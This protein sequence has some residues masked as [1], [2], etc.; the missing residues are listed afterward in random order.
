[1]MLLLFSLAAIASVLIGWRHGTPIEATEEAGFYPEKNHRL[2]DALLCSFVVSMFVVPAIVIGL[3][4]VFG[5]GDFFEAAGK[6]ILVQFF[7]FIINPGWLLLLAPFSLL[8]CVL[9]FGLRRI[10]EP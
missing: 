7:L 3:H 10:W 1:M 2:F 8:P 6:T 4:H 9:S 5:G